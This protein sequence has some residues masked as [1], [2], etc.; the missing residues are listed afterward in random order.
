MN[1][2]DQNINCASLTRKEREEQFRREIVLE[3]AE[4]LFAEKG[5]VHTTVADIARQSELAKGSLYQ[6]FQSKEEIFTAILDRKMSGVLEKLNDLLAGDISPTEK[7]HILI[8][9]KLEGFWDAKDWTKI[10]LNEL[11]GFHWSVDPCFIERHREQIHKYQKRVEEIIRDGQKAGELRNDISSSTLLAVF[12]GITNGVIHR[13]L[14]DPDSL[15]FEESVR[16][17][18]EIFLHGAA[19]QK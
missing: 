4:A 3:A 9:T 5:F 12:S 17:V 8:R 13:W 1:P 18:A 10:Y 16:K 7:I 14:H 2:G 19:A 6:L 11:R 15:D